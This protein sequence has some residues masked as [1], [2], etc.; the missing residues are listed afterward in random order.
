MQSNDS[1]EIK[2]KITSLGSWNRPI[3]TSS[4]GV[5]MTPAPLPPSYKMEIDQNYIALGFLLEGIDNAFCHMLVK[6]EDI[7]RL[8]LTI[9]DKL[10]IRIA[11]TK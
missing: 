2:A 9:G 1:F 11:P 8:N 5:V 10:S 7:K 3:L 6:R 4:D